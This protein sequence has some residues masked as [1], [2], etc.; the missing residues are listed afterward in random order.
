MFHSRWRYLLI[1]ALAILLVTIAAVTAFAK[2]GGPAKAVRPA[3][4]VR[5]L[6]RRVHH[7][8]CVAESLRS[9]ARADHAEVHRAHCR[10]L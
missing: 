4:F 1:G 10:E 5:Q 7:H 2:S 9:D 8:Q 3:E 6:V